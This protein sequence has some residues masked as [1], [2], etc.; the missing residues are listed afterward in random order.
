MYARAYMIQHTDPEQRLT[1]QI[2]MSNEDLIPK[3]LPKLMWN[4][5]RPKTVIKYF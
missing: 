4:G 3:L 5:K 2:D 1:K